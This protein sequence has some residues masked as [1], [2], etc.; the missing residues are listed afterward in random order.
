[1]FQLTNMAQ[2]HAPVYNKPE[3]TESNI[4]RILKFVN[5]T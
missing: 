3:S 1:M 5:P 2:N 4:F